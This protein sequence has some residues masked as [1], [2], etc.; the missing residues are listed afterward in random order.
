MDMMSCNYPQR[1]SSL[2]LRPPKLGKPELTKA[3]LSPFSLE[4]PV[5]ERQSE[6]LPPALTP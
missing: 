4:T 1:L 5:S 2:V 3:H 6:R